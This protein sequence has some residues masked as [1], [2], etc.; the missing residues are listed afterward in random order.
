[1]ILDSKLEPGGMA[2]VGLSWE[3]T[4]ARCPPNIMAACNNSAD[5]VSISGP[6][7]DVHK[8]AAELKQ[9]KHLCES[10]RQFWSC[11]P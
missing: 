6:V 3:E 10:C 7:E 9:Q 4:K 11:L 1:M 2:A 8:F 5:S